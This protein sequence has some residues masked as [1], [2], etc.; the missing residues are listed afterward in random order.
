MASLKVDP[1]NHMVSVLP[2]PKLKPLSIQMFTSHYISM[3]TGSEK[4][5][6][7]P[8]KHV[9]I[10]FYLFSAIIGISLF[11]QMPMFGDVS[12][13]ETGLLQVSPSWQFFFW[14]VT[15]IDRMSMTEVRVS[16]WELLS[17]EVS[18]NEKTIEY[19]VPFSNS[20]HT[21]AN[22]IHIWL[23]HCGSLIKTLA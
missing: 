22:A 6:T 23:W 20:Q 9:F 14:K 17:T 1:S 16:S 10:I 3:S 19:C 2:H 15:W 4:P 7:R 13:S 12:I 5:R 8:K 21:S 18:A 11:Q